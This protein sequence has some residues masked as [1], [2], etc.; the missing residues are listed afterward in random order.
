MGFFSYHRVQIFKKEE[1]VLAAEYKKSR[2]VR[3]HTT[4]AGIHLGAGGRNIKQR[5][6]Q[7]GLLYI[8]AL[9]STFVALYCVPCKI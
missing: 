6:I 9:N 8:S 7:Y 1:Y 5:N 4:S 3:Y 2:T